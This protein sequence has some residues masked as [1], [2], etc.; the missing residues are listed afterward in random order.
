M[1][2]TAEDICVP[3]EEVVIETAEI[4]I[5]DTSPSTSGS[6]MQQQ[7]V[8]HFPP[9]FENESFQ[10]LLESDDIN[11]ESDIPA[12]SPS[13][14]FSP[15][16]SYTE[17]LPPPTPDTASSM[18]SVAS[19]IPTFLRNGLKSSILEKR[20][21]AGKDEIKVEFLPPPPEQVLENNILPVSL[22]QMSKL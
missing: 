1:S 22:Y 17:S 11:I 5:Q 9:N 12:S 19:H 15:G 14:P 13:T 20:R 3:S 18:D 21:R 16:S 10:S 2:F 7:L 6:D 4:P 8:F